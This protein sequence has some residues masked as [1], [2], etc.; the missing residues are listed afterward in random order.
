MILSLRRL[1][2]ITL[3][4]LPIADAAAA[5]DVA[6]RRE[7]FFEERVRPLLI[8]RCYECHSD[9]KQESNLRLDSL[10]AVM[11]GGDSG[12]A[13][14]ARNVD[15]SLL[16]QAVRGELAQM[17]PDEPLTEEEMAIL[18]KWVAMGLPWPAGDAPAAPSLGDQIA[19][20]KAAETHW[21]FQPIQT[22]A[23]PKSQDGSTSTSPIDAFVNQGIA[24]ANLTPASK[25]DRR[26]LLRR[27]SFDL[28]GLPP[29]ADE[30]AAFIADDSDDAIEKVVSRLLQSPHHGER[31]GRHWLDVAR[32]ADSQD[33]QAQTDVRYPFAYTYRDWVIHAL[34]DDMPYDEFIRKQLAADA[35]EKQEDSPQLAALGFLTVGPRFRNNKLELNAD[36]ID[37]VTRGLMGLTVTCARCHD[38]KYDPV[39]IEDYYALYGVFASSAVPEE[40]PELSGASISE[41]LNMD[42]RKQL[43]KA[44]LAMTEYREGLR[45][46]AIEDLQ[47]RI[48]LYLDGFYDMGVTKKSE[49]RGVISKLKVK[50][51][52]M[53]PLNDRL[54]DLVRKGDKNDPVMGPWITGLRMSEAEFSKQAKTLVAAW[55]A[56]DAKFNAI[57]KTQLKVSKPTTRKALIDAYTV[58]FEEVLEQCRAGKSKNSKPANLDDPNAEAVRVAI[59]DDGGIFD[60]DVNRVVAASRLLGTGRKNLGDLEKGIGEVFAS[61]P[62][63]PPRAMILKDAE[64]LMSPYVMLRGEPTRRGDKVE[65]RFISLLSPETPKP[66]EHGS[67]R[68][69]LADHIVSKSNPLTARVMVNRVWSKYF[70]KGL[71][72]N[73]DD[74]GLR[75]APPHQPEL[76]DW[77]ASEF[78]NHNWS[79]KWLHRTIVM[80]DAYQR[81]CDA[82]D[83]A[84]QLDPENNSLAR[85]NRRRLDVEAMRD[86]ILATSDLLDPTIGGRSV[87]LSATPFTHRRTAYA[88][89]DRVDMDPMLKTFDIASPT[90][91]ASERPITM[92]PQQALFLMNHPMVAEFARQTASM[93][94]E[95]RSDEDAVKNMYER[96][97]Q[98]TP[99]DN[100][101]AMAMAFVSQPQ[102][103]QTD[104]PVI[105]S[106]GYGSTDR[107]AGDFTP[108]PHWS[109]QAYQA[110]DVLPD[111]IMRHVRLT[112]NGGN[113]MTKP[114]EG[115]IRRWTA[116]GS[117]TVRV[118]GK[119]SH[120]RDK[121]DGIVAQVYSPDAKLL[122]E[123]KVLQSSAESIVD[124]IEVEQGQSI[125]FLVHCFKNPASD[126]FTWA[127]IVV[128]VE[129]ELKGQT[130]NSLKDFAGPPPPKL[131]AWEQLAQALMLTNEFHFLD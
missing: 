101:L 119:V 17:P 83:T 19:I 76:L 108:L 127:P 35:I 103:S 29:T 94:R 47:K 65:R 92:I 39:P 77:L 25:A 34:N 27:L 73:V 36:Q 66:F 43:A 30:V 53:T 7:Q 90:A 46:E 23:V 105:W 15:D 109:G 31:W 4:C 52:G 3:F 116:P 124:A 87:Q 62:G 58:V 112:A 38:H 115:V 24:E 113:P 93:V 44:E 131:T 88:Y 121:S 68:L 79:M 86:A 123:S 16:I 80:S 111:P 13:A 54:V 56:E 67:G 130:W 48:K 98:R 128:G 100:E 41:E 33:W 22:P 89:I 61:H 72:E 1:S 45:N 49:I 50:E 75:C 12:A 2:I 20:K 126:S 51:T 110:S 74:F 42:F 40:L 96:L 64:T 18:E 26:T 28:I 63:A 14:V 9:K 37:V 97:F 11:R 21:A 118:E 120:V 117:G 78:M 5:D 91:S 84:V 70:G 95:N 71:V 82:S 69:D 85:Q 114:T 8:E 106:Y 59:M 6:N 122:W 125:E 60:L 57:V 32:Y 129:G 104:Q 10:S 99:T 81:S 55:T 102:R 107:T